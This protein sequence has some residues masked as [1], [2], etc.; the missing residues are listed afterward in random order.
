MM[1]K[2]QVTDKNS[3][4]SKDLEDVQSKKKKKPVDPVGKGKRRERGFIPKAKYR[5]SETDTVFIT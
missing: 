4:A 1:V 2:H 5:P 3:L